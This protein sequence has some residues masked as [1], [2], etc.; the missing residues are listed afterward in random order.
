MLG[1]DTL[2]LEVVVQRMLVVVALGLLAG[3]AAKRAARPSRV[4]DMLLVGIAMWIL[5]LVGTLSGHF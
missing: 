3:G 4:N 5:V 1:V 2:P